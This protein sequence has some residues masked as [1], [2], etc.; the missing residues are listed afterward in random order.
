MRQDLYFIDAKVT[1]DVSLR[2]CAASKEEAEAKARE[3]VASGC[4]VSV[5]ENPLRSDR[6]VVETLDP[7]WEILES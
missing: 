1:M 3:H 7:K 2:V 4:V 5:K 6:R